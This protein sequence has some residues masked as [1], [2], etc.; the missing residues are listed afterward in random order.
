M[1]FLKKLRFLSLYYIYIYYILYYIYKNQSDV[2]SKP[3]GGEYNTAEKRD[4]IFKARKMAELLG[5]SHMEFLCDIKVVDCIMG[6]GKTSAAINFMNSSPKE[7]KFMFIT[8]YLSEVQRIIDACPKLHFQEPK[9][10]G[11][12][13][14]GIKQL[15]QSKKNIV[16]THALFKHFDTEIIRLLKKRD[17]I[18]IMDE[19]ADVVE[20]YEMCTA[21]FRAMSSEMIDI[22]QDTGRLIWRK[23]KQHYSDKFKTERNLCSIGSLYNYADSGLMWVLPIEIFHA[24]KDIY[25]LTYMFEAQVQKYYYDFH[26][27]PYKQLYIKGDSIENYTFTDKKDESN[28]KTLDYRQLIHILSNNKLNAI[29]E[30]QYALSKNWYIR[31]S[32][33]EQMRHL[34][35]NLINYFKN[36]RNSKQKENLWTTFLAYKGEL[37]GGGYAKS[38]APLNTRGSNSYRTRTVVAY[39]LNRYMNAS[40]KNFFSQYGIMV[41]DDQ[42]ALSEM[43]QFIWRSAIRDG[44]EIWCY[45]PSRRMRGLLQQWIKEHSPEEGV[46]YARKNNEQTDF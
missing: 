22:A 14:N 5:E 36:I 46:E 44:H 39:P 10:I 38:F 32:G 33:T 7:K 43:L 2:N 41:D 16:S 15:V 40:V 29:G 1:Y 12:K 28:E 17:Y 27:I 13:L 6:S 23:G 24:F 4:K 9:A 20:Q 42:F 26:G 19:V 8:P 30:K 25:I 11:S 31:N 45:I 37:A 3:N 18:L 35:N 34:K 21:D